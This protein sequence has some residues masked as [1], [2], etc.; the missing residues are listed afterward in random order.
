MS[1]IKLSI[2][3]QSPVHDG[4]S[5]A[6]ALQDSVRLAQLADSLGYHR[7][8]VA[9]HHG[10]P[11]YAGSAPEILIGQIAAH[12]RNIRV[13]SGGVMLSHYSPYKVA[14]VFRTLDAFFPGRIDLGVGRAPG[15]AGQI[16]EALAY[17]H[18]PTA[19][20]RFPH[21]LEALTG[22]IDGNLPTGHAFQGLPT[23]PE[24]SKTSPQLWALGSSDGSIELAARLGWGFVLALFIGTHHRAADIISDYRKMFRSRSRD[25]DNTGP[26]MIANAVICA[27][28]RE[29]AEFL[30]ASHTYWKL[31]AHRHGI[32]EGL[33]D[34]AQCLDLYAQLPQSDRAF[35]DETRSGMILGTPEQCRER[36]EYQADYYDVDEVVA[37]AVTHSFEQRCESYR[38][39][40]SAFGLSD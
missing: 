32:R 7:Y 12:T 13:G 18:T 23:T 16:T 30:A 1:T 19:P 38:K 17:P 6:A 4:K 3:D 27:D 29:E 24:G 40:A 28:S 36:L 9:E 22:Y 26:A 37:V 20:N 2:V 14:E 11:S 34:P 15:G 21:L 39:L 10:T 31:Q 5:Q 33:R 25:G 8:W 35:F